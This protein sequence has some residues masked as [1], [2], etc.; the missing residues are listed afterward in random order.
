ML[1]PTI[2]Q[3]KVWNISET[4]HKSNTYDYP[5]LLLF[6]LF[7]CHAFCL[8]TIHFNFPELGFYMQISI[9]LKYTVPRHTSK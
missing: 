7:S 3:N 8:L 6:S 4:I 5:L 9:R 2:I 1:S